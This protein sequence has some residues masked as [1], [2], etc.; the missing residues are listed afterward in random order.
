MSLIWLLAVGNMRECWKNFHANTRILLVTI[1]ELYILFCELCQKKEVTNL[2][3]W[4]LYGFFFMIS[5]SIV[6]SISPSYLSGMDLFLVRAS[7]LSPWGFH[8]QE[9]SMK[10]PSVTRP[11]SIQKQFHLEMWLLIFFSKH[12]VSFSATEIFI[13]RPGNSPYYAEVRGLTER[14]EW[15]KP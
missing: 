7:A 11:F 4:M 8:W 14:K 3:W 15:I 13:C 1:T 10:K 9:L 6:R 12:Q 2:F 5:M